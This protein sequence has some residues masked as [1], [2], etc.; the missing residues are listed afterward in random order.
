[1]LNVND[2]LTHY[3]LQGDYIDEVFG[4]YPWVNGEV[5]YKHILKFTTKCWWPIIK[6]R[7]GPT[8][9]NNTLSAI[10]DCLVVTSILGVELSIPLIIIEKV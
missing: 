6:R 8:A 2:K 10:N 7:I 5:I 9:N 3:R 4:Y 1:M